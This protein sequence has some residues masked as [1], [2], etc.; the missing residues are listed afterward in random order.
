MSDLVCAHGQLSRQCET[1]KMVNEITA[2]KAECERLRELA[3]KT[4]H[5]YLDECAHCHCLIERPTDP[6]HCFDCRVDDDDHDAWINSVSELGA[7]LE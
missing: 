7:N 4:T 3:E 5:L 1:C 6:P 2:L